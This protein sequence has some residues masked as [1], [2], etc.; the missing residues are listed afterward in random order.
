MKVFLILATLFLLSFEG[1]VKT[2]DVVELADDGVK[3]CYC[4]E[5]NVDGSCSSCTDCPSGCCPELNWYC[6]PELYCAATAADCAKAD[7]R[8]ELWRM[9]AGKE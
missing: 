4:C 9:A 1:K 6:C 8:K 3:E 2:S 7:R 5:E